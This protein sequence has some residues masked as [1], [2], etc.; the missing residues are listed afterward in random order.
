MNATCFLF[1]NVGDIQWVTQ[2][3]IPDDVALSISIY[4]L[5]NQEN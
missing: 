4:S 5:S 3:H 2:L 1:R